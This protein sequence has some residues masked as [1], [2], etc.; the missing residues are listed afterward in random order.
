PLPHARSTA[1]PRQ[2]TCR[3]SLPSGRLFGGGDIFAH[4]ALLAGCKPLPHSFCDWIGGEKP[5]QFLRQA[6][7][8][9]AQAERDRIAR[10][11]PSL[12]TQRLRQLDEPALLVPPLD[13]ASPHLNAVQRAFD[14]RGSLKPP[15]RHGLGWHDHKARQLGVFTL[16][17]RCHSYRIGQGTRSAFWHMKPLYVANRCRRTPSSAA[18]A[19][20]ARPLTR[21]ITAPVRCS[22]WFGA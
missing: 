7:R 5:R 1:A 17:D 15:R 12:S 13:R 18:G 2:S 6:V 22:D 3:P 4:H 11:D 8:C 20:R 21:A 10:I 16:D 14:D 9:E 19:R